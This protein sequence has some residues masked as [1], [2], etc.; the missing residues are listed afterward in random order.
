M[1]E[2]AQVICIALSDGFEAEQ[3]AL[4]ERTRALMERHPLYPQLSATP[5]YGGPGRGLGHKQAPREEHTGRLRPAIERSFDPAIG[6]K[7][8]PSLARD[9][10][11]RL[12]WRRDAARR[13]PRAGAPRRGADA[14]AGADPPGPGARSSADLDQGRRGLQRLRRQQG[15][16]ARV[17]ARRRPPPRQADR[18]S[19]A[20]RWAPTTAWPRRCSPAGW[21]CGPCSSWCPSPTREH[22]RRQLE[23]IREAAPSSIFRG[24][25]GA[26]TCLPPRSWS[27]GPARRSNLPVLPAPRGLRAAGLRRLRR[28]GDRASRPDRGRRA[29]RALARR[30]RAGQRRDR[31]RAGSPG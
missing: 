4:L 24:A 29:A 26:P 8:S 21:A 15:A 13:R 18:S 3:D 20:A 9:G 22:V 19:P 2:I 17:A 6:G 16:Q 27:G 12:P 28:G 30:R 23:R 11:P 7:T 1:R 31:R 10:L 5:V 14:G 25:C